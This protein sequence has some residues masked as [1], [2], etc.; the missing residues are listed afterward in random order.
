MNYDKILVN[1]FFIDDWHFNQS[2]LNKYKRHYKTKSKYQNII[3]YINHRY[4]DSLSFRETLYRM[5]YNYEIR[6][7][8]KTCGNDVD[9][10]GKLGILFRTYCSNR[11][12]G[13][14]KDTIIKKQNSDKEKND[15]ILGWNKNNKE[16][17]Q[18]RKNTLINKYGS[19]KNACIEIEKLRK[20]GVITKYGVNSVMNIDYI[21]EK[22]YQSLKNNS[23]FNKSKD[24]ELSY[25]LLKE[26]YPDVLRQYKDDRYP[27]SCDFYIPSLDLFIECNYHWTHGGKLYENTN[28]DNI[29]LNNWKEKNTKYY[30]NAIN[31]WI[32]LDIK[33]LNIAKQNK[34]NYLIF[35]NIKQ[36]KKWIN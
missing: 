9:F 24:E 35:Y 16:K 14:N 18:S 13:I 33:K 21:K 34:L 30:N 29:K 36:L 4:K 23:S 22:H 7:K 6:P 15:G 32:N 11:C 8:C 28:E 1:I 12:S 25:I 19:W 31:T 2:Y 27:F 17:I 26:K 5:K 10:I 3:N 20:N